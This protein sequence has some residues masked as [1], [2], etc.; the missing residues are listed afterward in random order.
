M[1]LL[2]IPFHDIAVDSMANPSVL[3][4]HLKQSKTDQYHRDIDTYVGPTWLNFAVACP[5]TRM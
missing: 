5:S 1:I 3:K 4:I 2:N